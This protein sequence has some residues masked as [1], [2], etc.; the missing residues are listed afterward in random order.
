MIIREKNWFQERITNEYYKRER[1]EGHLVTNK[2][3]TWS[4][5]IS[6]QTVLITKGKIIT[7]WRKQTTS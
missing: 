1:S 6:K 4:Q 3:N 5:H 7:I 2:I